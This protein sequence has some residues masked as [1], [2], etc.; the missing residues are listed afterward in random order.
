MSVFEKLTLLVQV[1]DAATGGTLL[2]LVAGLLILLM[3]A[4]V[5]WVWRRLRRI[6]DP[7]NQVQR[8]LNEDAARHDEADE[9]AAEWRRLSE[10]RDR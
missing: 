7:P 9:L 6:P 8:L 1:A 10:E 4:A 3:V 5:S 2:P